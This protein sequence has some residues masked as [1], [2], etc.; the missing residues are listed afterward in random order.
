MIFEAGGI[1]M[2]TTS[3]NYDLIQ[4]WLDPEPRTTFTVQGY[5]KNGVN[6]NKKRTLCPHVLGYTRNGVPH[7]TPENERVLCWQL[8]GPGENPRWCC[9]KVTE[10]VGVAP[11]PG[12]TWESSPDYSRHQNCV[13]KEKFQVPYPPG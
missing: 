8:E 1:E 9:Y 11:D 6:D 4:Q 3:D 7:Q 13:K 2:G 5:K 10:L 12:T